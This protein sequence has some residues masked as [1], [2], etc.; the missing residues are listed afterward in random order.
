MPDAWAARNCRQA[1]D[2]RRNAEPRPAAARIRQIVPSPTWCPRPSNLTLG[3][4]VAPATILPCQ[5]LDQRPHLVRDRRSSRRIWIGPFLRG[6]TAVPGRQGNRGHDAVQPQVF[7]Q[8]PGQGGEDGPIS[9][10]RSRAGDLA[11]QHRDLVTQHEDLR[12]FRGGTACQQDQ[13]PNT[14]TMKR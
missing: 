12:T 5:L 6:Q 3:P 14:Q 9:S 7:G 1:G 11:T 4:A 10:V 13:H 2:A 8:Q